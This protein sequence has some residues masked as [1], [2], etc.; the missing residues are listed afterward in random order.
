MIVVYEVVNIGLVT[1][2]KK[3]T[4]AKICQALTARNQWSPR[5]PRSWGAALDVQAWHDARRA[6]FRA[7]DRPNFGGLVLGCIEAN[8]CK[9]F[10]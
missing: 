7:A 9:L 10:V 8:L 6:A 1:P 2:P 5:A 4:F 3:E